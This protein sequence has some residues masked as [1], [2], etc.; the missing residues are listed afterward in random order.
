MNQ[1]LFLLMGAVGLIGLGSLLSSNDDAHGPDEPSDPYGDRTVIEGTDG[2]DTITGTT[3]DEA[4][5]SDGGGDRGTG[6]DDLVDGGGGNDLIW[7]G[8]GE[9]TV[10]AQSGNDEVYL[11]RDDDLYGAYDPGVN[12]GN[13][14]IVGGSRN[15]VIITNGGQHEIYGDDQPGNIDYDDYEPSGEDSIYDNGGSVY[16]YAGKG[17]DLIWSPD[18][19]DPDARDTLLGGDGNDTIYAGGYDSIDG[20]KGSDLYVLRGDASGPADINYGSS[21]SIQIALPD[22]YTGA[23]EYE[24]IQDGDNVRLVLD[25]RDVALL[26]EV[27]ARDVRAISFITMEDTPQPPWLS[28]GS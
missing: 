17:D 16:V 12:E 9:D 7:T 20:G 5:L 18:D 27:E 2:E 19:S 3:E 28:S 24:L 14:T 26:H 21:D 23:G 11:G 22:N 4:I 6:G 13:D 8:Y 10:I 15:D 1:T 25:G